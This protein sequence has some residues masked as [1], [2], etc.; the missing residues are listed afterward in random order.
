VEYA[1]QEVEDRRYRRGRNVVMKAGR[2][3][4]ELQAGR[5]KGWEGRED[6]VWEDDQ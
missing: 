6:M 1:G 2:W 4:M 5:G 3:R